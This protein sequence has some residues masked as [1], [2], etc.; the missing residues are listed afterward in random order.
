MAEIT[1]RRQG[2]LMPGVFRI[3]QQRPHPRRL[4]TLSLGHSS[5][6]LPITRGDYQWHVSCASC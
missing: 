3:L 6:T 1:R 5:S 2:E 4:D